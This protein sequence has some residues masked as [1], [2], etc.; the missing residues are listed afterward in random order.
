MSDRSTIIRLCK[1]CRG[2]KTLIISIR[3]F[4]PADTVLRHVYMQARVCGLTLLKFF[5]RSFA[6]HQVFRG[7]KS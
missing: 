2:A 5:A 1:K 7:F 4:L 3:R 6:L